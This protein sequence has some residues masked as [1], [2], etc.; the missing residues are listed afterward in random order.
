MIKHCNSPNKNILEQ[1]SKN[2]SNYCLWYSNFV[3]KKLGGGRSN[4]CKQKLFFA[5]TFPLS[6]FLGYNDEMSIHLK[7]NNKNADHK[8]DT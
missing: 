3:L 2:D 6:H 5:F 1:G 4:I 7:V 8:A